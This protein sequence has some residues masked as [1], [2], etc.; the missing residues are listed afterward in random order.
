[1]QWIRPMAKWHPLQSHVLDDKFRCEFNIDLQDS[2][3]PSEEL[4]GGLFE[5]APKLFWPCSG[6]RRAIKDILLDREECQLHY[7]VHKKQYVFTDRS[8]IALG[9][10]TLNFE[11]NFVLWIYP[12]ESR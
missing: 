11:Y 7:D 8:E 2:E 10:I 4:N 1:L 6:H 12:F 3:P 5:N 9:N